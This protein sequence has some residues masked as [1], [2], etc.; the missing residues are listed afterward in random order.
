MA[1]VNRD[2]DD[3]RYD[4]QSWMWSCWPARDWTSQISYEAVASV[5]R[6]LNVIEARMRFITIGTKYN[7]P[8]ASANGDSDDDRYDIVGCGAAGQPATGP[9]RSATRLY[10]FES[11]TDWKANML[12][13]ADV[14]MDALRLVEDDNITP[15]SLS[16]SVVCYIIMKDKKHEMCSSYRPRN[17]AMGIDF[18]PGIQ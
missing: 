9:L 14:K 11:A 4:K 12:S 16:L 8:L 7:P 2:S 13:L 17:V 3:D 15:L 1:S 10:Q 6:E 5:V 18:V